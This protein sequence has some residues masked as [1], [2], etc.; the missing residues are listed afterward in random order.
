MKFA[1]RLEAGDAG[2]GGANFGGFRRVA[3]AEAFEQA[4]AEG[5]HARIEISPDKKK[6]EGNREVILILECV[7]DRGGEIDA[8]ENFGVG[9]PAGAFAVFAFEPGA[10]LALRFDAILRRADEFGL[11]AENRFEDGDGVAHREADADGH[12]ER[13][14]ED[15]AIPRFRIEDA[16]GGEIETGDGASGR[17][18]QREV[19]QEH[20]EPALIEADD[21]RG[22]QNHGE[23]N[24]QRVADVG[25][26]VEKRFGFNVAGN[27]G[28]QDARK[29]F[30]GGLHQ[31]LGPARLLGFE[32]VHLD[33]QLG[34][35]IN[36]GK[37]N[38]F[39]AAKLS[40]IGEIGVFGERVVLPAAGIFDG[41][42]APDAAGA[43]EIE[44]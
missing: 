22:K 21:H 24:H 35:A 30:E 37:I 36:F 34:G 9:N 7:D 10:A 26:E 42:A 17:Q 38:E 32:G 14:V 8:E 28:A 40:A 39:P 25:G 15:C 11:L 4:L 20:L 33:G 13:H 23:Q 19:N 1:W 2:G 27:V 43:I 6:Q 41:G 12:D 18:K 5:H 31:A 16:F 44:K 3:E 29:D